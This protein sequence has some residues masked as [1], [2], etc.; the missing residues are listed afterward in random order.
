[1]PADLPNSTKSSF[2]FH[3][4]DITVDHELRILLFFE[5]NTNNVS[6]FYLKYK[7]FKKTYLGCTR[8]VVGRFDELGS[9]EPQELRG[10]IR[11]YVRAKPLSEEEARA[12]VASVVRCDSDHRV[13]CFFQGS[14]KVAPLWPSQAPAPHYNELSCVSYSVRF[15]APGTVFW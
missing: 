12:G 1:M 7:V 13:S 2:I 15:A 3:C 14:T 9:R 4:L 6:Q 11:V 8:L 10:N 5:A